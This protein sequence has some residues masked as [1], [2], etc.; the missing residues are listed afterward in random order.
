MTAAVIGAGAIGARLDT[1][2]TT[3]PLTHAGGYVA[4]GYRLVG[5]VDPAADV[6]ELAKAWCCQAF[7]SVDALAAVS[8]DVVSIAAPTAAHGPLLREVAALRP[9]AVVAEKP[10]A[11]SL[12]E[13]EA[14]VD[15]YRSAGIPLVVNYTRR[16]TPLWRTVAP[17]SAMSA[18]F[19]YGKGLQ[20]NG[21]HAID[22][23]RMLFGEC[24]K[25]QPLASRTDFW[26]DDPSVSAFLSFERCPE[27]FL[28]A[29]DERCFTYFEADIVA[30]GWRLVVDH[31]GRRARRFV[32]R[33]G[34]GVP[35][36]R[37]LVETGVEDTGVS[38][39]VLS[40]MNHLHDVIQG[41]PPWC[42]GDDA[43]AAQRIA[44]RIRS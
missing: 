21:T 43:V 35:K 33:D 16:F 11:G 36:G 42:S 2:A 44:A 6:G 31:D 18:T 23:C 39:P 8:P 15:L 3:R 30:P 12:A 20:H 38:E 10:L 40:L 4:A 37:R 32:T 17:C 1:P 27:V 28:Q 24:V 13:A 29:M 5:L 26:P 25:A 14:I 34:V 22:L 41:A 19:R 9:R 7:A